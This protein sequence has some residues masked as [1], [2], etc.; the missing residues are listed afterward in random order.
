MTFV[1]FLVEN[2]FLFKKP[3]VVLLHKIML[4][5]FGSVIDFRYGCKEAL[6]E[7]A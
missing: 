4:T 5:I 3:Q 7:I 2:I 1:Q 6:F